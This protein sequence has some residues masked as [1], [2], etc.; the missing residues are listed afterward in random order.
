M[1]SV[2]PLDVPFGMSS[3]RAKEPNPFASGLPPVA[4]ATMPYVPPTPRSRVFVAK[5]P[6]TFNDPISELTDEELWDEI[7]G[8]GMPLLDDIVLLARGWQRGNPL[9]VVGKA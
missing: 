7:F 9:G 3:G 8:T 5:T 4:P 6:S 2:S 1:T